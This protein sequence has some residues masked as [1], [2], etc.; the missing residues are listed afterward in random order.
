MGHEVN[1][2][3]RDFFFIEGIISSTLYHGSF[4]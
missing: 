2:A 4:L 1:T 3:L